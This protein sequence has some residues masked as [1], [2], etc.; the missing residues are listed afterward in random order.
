VDP[1]DTR[2]RMEESPAQAPDAFGDLVISGRVVHEGETPVRF[3]EVRLEVTD[4]EERVIDCDTAPI[5]S[6]APAPVDGMPGGTTLEPGGR[7]TFA[8]LVET[9]FV[10]GL[11]VR[12]WTTLGE[13]A[14]GAPVTPVYQGLQDELRAL[15]AADEQ[16]SSP[17]SRAAR[18]NALRRESR[19][20]ERLARER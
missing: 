18:R 8:T 2:V 4:A 5:R 19:E 13:N 14:D 3:G 11:R 10:P 16:D 6:A 1:L 12:A 17:Q 7:G 20:I 15:L 9:V